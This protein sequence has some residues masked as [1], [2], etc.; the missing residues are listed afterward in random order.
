MV[1]YL[2]LVLRFCRG[3]GKIGAKRQI[4]NLMIGN[5]VFDTPDPDGF[6]YAVL[7]DRILEAASAEDW[8]L[9]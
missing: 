7:H 1:G 9:I 2:K 6:F 5:G 8:S 3:V 4:D